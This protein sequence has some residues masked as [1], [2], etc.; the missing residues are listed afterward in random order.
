[1]TAD[2]LMRAVGLGP[3]DPVPVAE[4]ES[5]EGEAPEART[6]ELPRYRD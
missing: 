2:E 1:M 6:V 4:T 3:Q 5:P